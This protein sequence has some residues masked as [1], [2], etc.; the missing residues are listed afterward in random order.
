MMENQSIKILVADDH[1]LFRQGIIRL[2][3]DHKG[4]LVIAEAENGEDLVDKYFKFFPDLMIVDIA[5]PGTSGIRAIEEIHKISPDA[6]A[7]FLSMYDAPEYVYKVLKS[8]GMGLLNKNILD[9]ELVYAIEKVCAGEKYFGGRWNENSLKK[10]V[11]DYEADEQKITDTNKI[12]LNFREEQVLKLI[13]AGSTSKEIGEEVDI[14]KK[15]VDYYRANLIRKTE[16]K[17]QADLI[18]FGLEYFGKKNNPE[19]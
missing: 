8:G 18:K 13:V 2:L 16:A 11:K 3:Y 6:K 12:E 9:S 19:L 5:M 14:S 10:L 17:S 1:T 15:T 4:F 7:L